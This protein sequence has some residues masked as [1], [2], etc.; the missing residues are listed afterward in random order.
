MNSL[1]MEQ[2]IS[3]GQAGKLQGKFIGKLG[4]GNLVSDIA[5]PP[6][7]IHGRKLLSLA[8]FVGRYSSIT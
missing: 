2:G 7:A 1:R 6:F 8:S 4:R 5:E 3:L